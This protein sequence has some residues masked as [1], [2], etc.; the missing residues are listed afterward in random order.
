MEATAV[1]NVI[2]VA[3]LLLALF[4]VAAQAVNSFRIAS[5]TQRS[6]EAER[7][8]LRE[9]I[10]DI[11]VHREFERKRGEFSWNGHRKFEV[12]SK[13]MEA[14]DVYSFYLKPHDN[15]ALPGYYPG[16]YLTF[17]LPLPGSKSPTVRCY[18]LSDGPREDCYR[19]TVKRQPP[20]RDPA[21]ANKDKSSSNWLHDVVKEGDIL[22]VKAPAG[23]FYLDTAIARPVVLIGGGIGLTPTLSML[24]TLVDRND[25]R[26]IWYV[27]GGRNSK[28]HAFKTFMEDIAR[29]YPNVNYVCCYSEPQPDDREGRD[30]THEGWVSVDLLKSLLPSNNYDFFFCG[31]P[32]MM[33]SLFEGLTQWGVPESRIHY[34]AFGPASVK[35]KGQAAEAEK[36]AAEGQE[37]TVTFARSGKTVTWSPDTHAL[38]DFAE[39]LG[40]AI[41]SGCRAGNC[42]SCEVAIKEGEVIYHHE[43]GYGVGAGS[44]LTC[45][46]VPKNNL[47]LEA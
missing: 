42:G 45:C 28:D 29:D 17:R 23:H 36:K 19:I 41:E 44:C 1:V 9:R 38:L 32:P 21:K 5:F 37:I 11:T 46:S 40:I 2:A 10:A 27:Y 39:E 6:I 16:Q 33:T 47:V 26:E 20:P 8:L 31:P 13:V 25:N 30:Y 35:P 34:E 12:A 3:V 14:E 43:P 18:S 7:E 24:S 22:D 15:K 4:Y